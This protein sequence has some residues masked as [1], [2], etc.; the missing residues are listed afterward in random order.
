MLIDA[1]KSEEEVGAD[2]KVII[3]LA[4]SHL[5]DLSKQYAKWAMA[6]LNPE[7]SA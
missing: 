2:Q 6:Q 3:R 4:H 1:G 5:V 7:A